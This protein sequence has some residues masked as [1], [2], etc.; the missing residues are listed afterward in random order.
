ME[1]TLSRRFTQRG[2]NMSFW[3]RFNVS[4][5]VCT[6]TVFAQNSVRYDFISISLMMYEK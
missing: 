4:L 1:L 3:I 5:S 2:L 6:S